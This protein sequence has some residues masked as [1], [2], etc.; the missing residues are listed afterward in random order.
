MLSL[1]IAF[2]TTFLRLAR[3]PRQIEDR[4]PAI[5]HERLSDALTAIAWHPAA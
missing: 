5:I 1:R 2:S 3:H 4:L